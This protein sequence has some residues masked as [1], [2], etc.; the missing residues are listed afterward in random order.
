MY[1][2]LEKSFHCHQRIKKNDYPGIYLK[3]NK[4]RDCWQV[5]SNDVMSHEKENFFLGFHKR[6]LISLSLSF[7]GGGKKNIRDTMKVFY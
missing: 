1:S 3:Q 2:P 7:R 4:S 5:L 6:S